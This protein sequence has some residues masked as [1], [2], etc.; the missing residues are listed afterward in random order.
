MTRG[1]WQRKRLKD[2]IER[3]IEA[4]NT[5]SCIR[6]ALVNQSERDVHTDVIQGQIVDVRMTC[7]KREK[8]WKDD[9][10]ITKAL[11]QDQIKAIQG[12]DMDCMSLAY[13]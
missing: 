2:E 10:H 1:R 6:V 5:E 4:R 13:R 11:L 3:R 7:Q 8:L 12:T 9:M